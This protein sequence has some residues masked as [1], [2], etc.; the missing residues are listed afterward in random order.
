MNLENILILFIWLIFVFIY[1]PMKFYNYKK[2]MRLTKIKTN[3]VT[4]YRKYRAL[5]KLT[6]YSGG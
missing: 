1:L 4:F 5:K 6:K 2:V 3:S